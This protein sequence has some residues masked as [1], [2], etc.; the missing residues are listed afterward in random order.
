MASWRP[1]LQGADA[2]RAWAAIHD[3]AAALQPQSENIDPSV[4]P[5]VAGGTAG[6]ALFY[7]YLG[8]ATGHEAWTSVAQRLIESSIDAVAERPLH[9][10]LYEGFS[11]IAWAAGHLQSMLFDDDEDGDDDPI[12][13]SVLQLLSRPELFAR[14][15]FDLIGGVSG[16]GIYAFDALPRP[17]ARRLLEQLA[18]RL[19]EIGEPAGD[20]GFSWWTPPDHIPE[21]ELEEWPNGQFNL[22]VSH[23]VAGVL[24]VLGLCAGA[25]ALS[26]EQRSLLDRAVNWLLE[27]KQVGKSWS[28][29][30]AV[31][32]GKPSRRE[33]MAWCYG[34]PGIAAALFATA[35]HCRNRQ[36]ET[37]ALDVARTAAGRPMND[38][39]VK[40]AGICHGAAGLAHLF[41]RMHQASSD[42]LLAE[43]AEA[44]YRRTLDLRRPGS[45]AG[46]YEFYING[47]WFPLTRF[48]DGAAGVGLALLG[49]VTSLEP[50]WD[51]FLAV[52]IPLEPRSPGS[53]ATS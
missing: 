3:I 50:S 5:G 10:D 14:G 4:P 39:G 19:A 40:D 45:G 12:G 23:G 52:S 48:V 53:I 29:P 25:D 26:V 15:D 47:E 2:E 46:G 28:F 44:W 51:R 17:T 49:G 13:Q 31:I 43:A 30:H 20:R 6:L 27:Q 21:W 33:R 18:Q 37:A 24:A 38:S 16:Y 41:N 36:W 35:R 22:G 42:P 32:E 8:A 7:A 11:G 1:L 34:D 9:P